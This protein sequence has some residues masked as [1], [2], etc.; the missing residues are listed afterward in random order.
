MD[1]AVR[2]PHLLAPAS[3]MRHKVADYAKWKRAFDAHGATRKKN[4]SKGGRLFR[5]ADDPSEVVILLKWSDLRK[6]REFITSDDVRQAMGRAGVSDQPTVYF[7]EERAR[8][9]G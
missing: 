2:L 4:G 6:A 1:P 3:R 8:P 7:L 9:A 5:S